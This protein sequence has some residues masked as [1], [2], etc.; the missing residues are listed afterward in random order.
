MAMKVTSALLAL[1][2]QNPKEDIRIYIN[3]PGGQIYSVMAIYDV[4]HSIKPDVSAVAL[5]LC[6]STSNII[7][8]VTINLHSS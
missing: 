8:A 4:M 6:A 1:E 2:V 5:G 7:L 3:C